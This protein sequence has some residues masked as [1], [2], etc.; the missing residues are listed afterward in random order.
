MTDVYVLDADLQLIGIVDAY[1]SL[2]WAS[3]YQDIGDCE[4]YVPASI[5]NLDLLQIGRFLTMADSDMICQINRIQLDTDAED[6]NYL[7]ASGVDVKQWLDRRIVWTTMQTQG[8]AENFIRQMVN[9]ALGAGADDARQMQDSTGRLMFG[10]GT[11][12][13]FDTPLTTQVSYKNV[14]EKVRELCVTYGWGYRVRLD[15]DV[16]RFELYSGADRSDSVIF[17][18]DYDNLATTTYSRDETSMGNVALVAGEGQGSD[19]AKVDAGSA[20]GLNRF[21][22]YVDAKDISRSIEYSELART[23]PGGAFVAVEGGYDYVVPSVDIQ[24][25]DENQLT[26][27]QAKYPGGVIVT[28]DGVQYYRVQDVAIAFSEKE[29]PEDNETVVL[30]DIIYDVYLLIRGYENLAEY[31]AVTSFDGTIIPDYTFVYKQDYFLGDI[32]TIQ[33]EYGITV[34]ARITEIVEVNDDNG[35]S[36][37]PKFKYISQEG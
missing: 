37:E 28:V 8:K 20:E 12:Q 32:V 34:Q 5:D 27:L 21:E 2:I 19:R 4:L 29:E 22:I 31:G 1:K 23:Y 3:R 7:T 9:D 30:Y 11:A 13:G 10:L 15:D 35:Y 17:S 36:I 18:D 33:N 25:I 14:G 26:E 24:I 6:G 16:L